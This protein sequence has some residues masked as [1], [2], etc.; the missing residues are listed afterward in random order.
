MVLS[1]DLFAIVPAKI[2]DA[3]VDMTIVGGKMFQSI[4]R[5]AEFENTVPIPAGS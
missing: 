1:D 3:H 2:K 5:L 4:V